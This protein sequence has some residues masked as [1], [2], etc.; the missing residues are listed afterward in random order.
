MKF[1]KNNVIKKLFSV[2]IIGTV[3]YYFYNSLNRNWSVV[4]QL[5]F[6]FNWLS[7][8]AIIS[9]VLAVVVSGYLWGNTLNILTV[10]QNLKIK[11]SEAIRIHIAS[12]L[13]KYIP[14]QAGSVINKVLWGKNKGYSKKL[15]LITF[16]YEN[17][18]LIIASFLLS[19][20]LLL[21]SSG[22]DEFTNNPI[23]ILVIILSL[24][25][26]AII[27][28]E[29]SMYA[30]TNFIFSKILKQPVGKELFLE[31][32][33]SI[34]LLLLYMIPR[35]LNALGFIF[36]TASFLRVDYVTYI[37]LGAAYIIGGAIGIMALFV[38]S[39]IGVREAV[40]VL[41]STPFIGSAP[42][43]VVAIIARLYSTLADGVLA[44]GYILLNLINKK[45]ERQ[46][47]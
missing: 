37:P 34:K 6:N 32:T 15:I 42:A 18:F 23:Y 3:G 16:I 22:Y 39:G 25:S 30:I 4:S 44:A 20:P 35:I 40:I 1:L 12:W 2:L 19:V 36:V 7:I 29:K 46:N 13:L 21:I 5:E 14:G 43:I 38:P 31:T 24:L 11:K 8:L 10:K 26:A 47:K 9:F 27:L 33:Q 28:N 45:A 17:I 41:F